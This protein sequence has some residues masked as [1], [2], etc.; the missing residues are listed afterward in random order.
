M[1][2][3]LPELTLVGFAKATLAA[4]EEQEL[5]IAIAARRMQVWD[6]G[7]TGVAGPVR[8]LV[9]RSSIDLPFTITI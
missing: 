9:G 4:G 5:R 7:W 8:L 3:D 1:Y 6:G 2:R